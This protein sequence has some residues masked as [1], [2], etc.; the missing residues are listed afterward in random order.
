MLELPR[1]LDIEGYQERL[2][3]HLQFVNYEI[4]RILK[5]IT[6]DKI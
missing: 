3:T 2:S 1:A 6:M 4:F 5:K